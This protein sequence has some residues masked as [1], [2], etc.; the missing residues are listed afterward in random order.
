MNALSRKEQTMSTEENKVIARRFFEEIWNKGRVELL[1]DFWKIEKPDIAELKERILWYHKSAPGFYFTI[2][3]VIAEGDKVLV[4]WKADVMH[5]NI[6]DPQPTFHIP[7]LGKPVQ[8]R[9][10]A[11]MTI[12]DG[13]LVAKE[14]ANL[15]M[16]MLI[17]AGVYV[18]A[19][20][21][22]A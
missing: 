7:P 19:K 18:L 16:G 22:P 9:G 15:A 4:Y 21:E 13:K 1:D 20:P 10:M 3:D 5:T 2:L 12:L 14:D 8:W 11:L 6:P 17:D